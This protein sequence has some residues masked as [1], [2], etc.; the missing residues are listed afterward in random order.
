M[1]NEGQLGIDRYSQSTAGVSWPGSDSV[2]LS[3]RAE[4]CAV[5]RGR[6]RRLYKVI[7]PGFLI[8]FL[9]D[10]KGPEK[11]LFVV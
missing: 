7:F 3:R 10:F 11:N 9:P 8:Q 4:V 2:E 6:L 1:W 5:A